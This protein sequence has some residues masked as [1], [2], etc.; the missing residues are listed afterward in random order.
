[1]QRN[2]SMPLSC[3]SNEELVLRVD[4]MEQASA[5]ERELA[6]RLDQAQ[7]KIDGMTAYLVNND[8]VETKTFLIQ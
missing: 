7:E 6:D 3:Y 1:M 5:L 2:D 8:L 4:N